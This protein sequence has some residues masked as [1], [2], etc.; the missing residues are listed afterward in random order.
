MKKRIF[1]KTPTRIDTDATATWYAQY[2]GWHCDCGHCRNFLALAERKALPERTR[3]VL[4]GLG[5]LPEKPTYVCTLDTN[6]AGILYQFSYRV[7]GTI[8]KAM[9]NDRTADG[10]TGCAFHEPYPYGAPGF[11][12]PHFDIE[13]IITLPWAL[14]EPQS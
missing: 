5:V 10:E 2:E 4:A 11:P 12:E 1:G 7:A 9:L 14:D 6:D 13:F 8:T 3:A